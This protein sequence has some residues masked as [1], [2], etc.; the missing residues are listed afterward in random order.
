MDLIAGVRI[1]ELLN[2]SVE[3]VIIPRTKMMEN[4]QK[5]VRDIGVLVKCSNKKYHWSP[6]GEEKDNGQ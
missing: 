1:S 4:M 6:G 2:R 3:N 5:K